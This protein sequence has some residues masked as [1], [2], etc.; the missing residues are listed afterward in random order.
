[1]LVV[2][3]T[4]LADS[5]IGGEQCQPAA[6]KLLLEDAYWITV[7]LWRLE[8]GNVLRNQVR[9]KLTQLPAA[10]A[11]RYMAAAET[12]VAETVDELDAEAVLE[13]ALTSGLTMYDASYVWL[14]RSRGL[15][16]RTR[17]K[18]ILAF[19]PDVAVPMPLV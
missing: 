17:D 7:G 19:C 1:M 9:S 14:A 6:E 10:D 3:A 15:K 4:V 16:L 12:L 11:L 18:D 2:D 13:L 5:L 8:L